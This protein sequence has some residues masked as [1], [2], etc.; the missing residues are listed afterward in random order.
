MN[1]PWEENGTSMGNWIAEYCTRGSAG[2]Y[3][4]KLFEK[5]MEYW[6]LGKDYKSLRF[7]RRPNWGE[8]EQGQGDALSGCGITIATAVRASSPLRTGAGGLKS[9]KALREALEVA[10]L[11]EDHISAGS[12]A[13]AI[14]VPLLL[15]AEASTAAAAAAS[16]PLPP[17]LQ[18]E[19][20]AELVSAK[21]ALLA[22][23]GV[24]QKRGRYPVSAEAQLRAHARGAG[25]PAPQLAS[26]Q[27]QLQPLLARM[28][29]ERARLRAF[30]QQDPT[31]DLYNVWLAMACQRQPAWQLPEQRLAPCT[32]PSMTWWRAAFAPFPP[33]LPC[34]GTFSTMSSTLK[35][36][37]SRALA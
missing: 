1:G 5:C 2:V 19:G 28:A 22:S 36:A 27:Q 6:A 34:A 16:A 26:A 35:R 8:D 30:A 14:P 3:D 10:R 17:P 11:E 7:E 31:L 18:P 23:L 4:A 12:E 37:T 29:A 32:C 15:E 24:A 25:W 13:E 9:F 21:R 33:S 20:M